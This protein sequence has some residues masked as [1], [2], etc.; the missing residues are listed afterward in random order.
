MP[1]YRFVGDIQTTARQ[2]VDNGAGPQSIH[3]GW[4]NRGQRRMGIGG[5]ALLLIIYLLIS[6]ER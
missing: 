2:T 4:P 5:M 6:A 1:I 3:H